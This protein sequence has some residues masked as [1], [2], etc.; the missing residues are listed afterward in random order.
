MTRRVRAEN[1]GG[2]T[3][4][5]ERIFSLCLNLPSMDYDLITLY[6]RHTKE[7]NI[8]RRALAHGIQGVESKRG[9]SG[10]CQNPFAALVEKKADENHGIAYGSIPGTF[11]RFANVTLTIPLALLWV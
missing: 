2:G 1:T 7:R 4:E 10:H 11:Q 5:I 8:E 6:G 3:L 9:V